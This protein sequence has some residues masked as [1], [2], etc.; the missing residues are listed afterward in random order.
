MTPLEYLLQFVRFTHLTH[1]VERVAR[2]AGETR[3]ANTVEHSYQLTLLAWYL[4][5]K[6]KLP[7]NKD[8]VIKYAL[9]HDL[10]ETYAGDTYAH[11]TEGKD[12][13]VLREHEAQE[14]IALEFPEF[15]DLHEYIQKYETKLDPESRFVY[16]LDKLIDP[17]NIYLEDGKLWH[18]K[19]VTL[20][21]VLDY[22]TEK[23]A[24]DPT[25]SKYFAELVTLLRKKEDILFPKNNTF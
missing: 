2:I 14:R 6:E 25:V 18:E 3:Y 7:L 12:S 5:E 20:Q 11:G 24:V 9:V 17:V 15:S 10:V 16:A 1:K 22:K 21:E 8:L 4:I 19:N 23:I 13:K